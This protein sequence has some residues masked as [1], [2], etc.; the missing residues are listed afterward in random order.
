MV[1]SGKRRGGG[2]DMREGK[3]VRLVIARA[4]SCATYLLTYDGIR[5]S[6]SMHK[7]MAAPMPQCGHTGAAMAAQHCGTAMA[8]HQAVLFIITS[9]CSCLTAHGCLAGYSF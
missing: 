7:R 3:R 2:G 1:V 9:S 8:A 6:N 4:M 5:V